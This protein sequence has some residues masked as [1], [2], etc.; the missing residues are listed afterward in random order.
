MLIHALTGRFTSHHRNRA[1]LYLQWIYADT[2]DIEALCARIEEAIAPFRPALELLISI[3]GFST[4]IAE[5]FILGRLLPGVQRIRR[6][7]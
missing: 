4:T 5:V 1:E 2:A 7:P 3:P 6:M